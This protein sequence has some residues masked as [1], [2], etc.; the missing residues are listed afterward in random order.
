MTSAP[1]EPTAKPRRQVWFP[2]T[3]ALV[4]LAVHTP[5]QQ[6]VVATLSTHDR[7]LVDAV[8]AELHGLAATVGP[9]SGWAGAA[10][11]QLDWLGTPVR[12]DDPV[13]T[14]LAVELQEQIA[15]GRALSHAMQHYGEAAIISLASRARY[16]RPLMLSDD[17]DARV[18]AKNHDVEPVSVHKLLHLMI[19][20]G[21]VAAD[22][23]ASF[24]N[25]LNTA[26]RA[27]DYTA[28]DLASG[29][30]GRVGQP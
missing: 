2:D 29:H 23:A 8:A 4:T 1:S 27:Q 21:K 19:R 11:K 9:V 20:Q 16:L 14:R 30:L 26:G 28:A 6:A 22:Q 3:S 25:A 10:L 24:A 5:L 13:G 7:V 18:A 17:Y 12:V 15:G